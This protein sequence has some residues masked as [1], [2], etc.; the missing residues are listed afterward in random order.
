MNL[1]HRVLVWWRERLEDAGWGKPRIGS[2]LN[3]PAF[4]ESLA[5]GT[6][7]PYAEEL[8]VRALLDAREEWMPL[9]EVL[10]DLFSAFV[11]HEHAE[12]YLWEVVAKDKD[13]W[14]NPDKFYAFVPKIQAL[15]QRGAR[16]VVAEC[17]RVTLQENQVQKVLEIIDAALPKGSGGGDTPLEEGPPGG[18]R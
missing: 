17:L 16:V 3:N 18:V 6:Y 11:I 9:S 8:I 2:I 1:G 4:Y 5:Y 7:D 10:E 14:N 12:A 15:I 13:I